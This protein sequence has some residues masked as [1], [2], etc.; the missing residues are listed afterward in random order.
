M[1]VR[2]V[3]ITSPLGPVLLTSSGSGVSGLFFDGAEPPELGWRH[4]AGH[5]AAAVQQLDEYFAGTLRRFTVDLDVRGT[6][7][8]RAV[9][10]QLLRIPYGETRSYG[11]LAAAVGRPAAARA[12]GAA[13]GRNPVSIIVPCHRLVGGDG[14][15]TGYGGGLDRKRA[16]LDLERRTVA[17]AA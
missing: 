14:R 1:T 13:N 16:L 17:G 11:Q 6:P 3:R 9:W 5:F 4:D 8:Q 15:L 2:C 12:V 10:G 7:F